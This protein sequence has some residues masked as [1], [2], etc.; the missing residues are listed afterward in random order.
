MVNVTTV[1]LEKPKAKIVI[2]SAA[3]LG[4][5]TECREDEILSAARKQNLAPPF[6]QM[7]SFLLMN[8]TEWF[9]SEAGTTLYVIVTPTIGKCFGSF[10]I[11]R[12]TDGMKMRW[13]PSQV[14]PPETKFIFVLS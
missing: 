13:R 9:P 7:K 3:E 1:A 11:K 8:R 12:C 10:E 4:Q 6:S 14:F 2:V 5:K